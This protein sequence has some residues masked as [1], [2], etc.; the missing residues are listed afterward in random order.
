MESRYGWT[1]FRDFTHAQL[2]EMLAA[3]RPPDLGPAVDGWRSLANLLDD[4]AL[5][6]ERE[7]GSFRGLWEGDAAAKHAAMIASLLDGV[8]QVAWAARRIGD[9]V[10][11]ASQA[12]R[13]AQEKMAA[14]GPPV[15]VRP[16]EP[17]VALAAST[18]PSYGEPGAAARQVAAVQAIQDFRRAQAAAAT[19]AGAAAAILEE[20]RNAYLNVDF[21]P[22]PAVAEPP[23]LA[24]DGTPVFP[25]TPGTGTGSPPLFT[26]LWR[27][28]LA[29]AAGMPP[30]GLLQ[31]YLPGGAGP[32]PS[33]PS[34]PLPGPGAGLPPLSDVGGSPV[35]LGAFPDGAAG[36]GSLPI[37]GFPGAGPEDEHV[38]A[39]GQ[40]ALAPAISPAKVGDGSGGRGMGMGMGMMPPFMGGFMPPG[41]A[42][43]GLGGANGG[44]A[45]WLVAEVEEFGVKAPVVPEVVD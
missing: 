17:A 24:A 44:A 39:V 34:D 14:L 6:L 36:G 43:G 35:R 45:A 37:G 1:Q 13:Q 28:G 3:G 29:A 30:A 33:Y 19:T 38:R 31:P 41:G 12:L 42:G 16:P 4:A 40:S 2:A 21:P 32:A 22:A 27:D 7:S 8:R 26:G 18:P 23:T 5:I 15:D 10:S 9:Q 25:P 11:A 20:L